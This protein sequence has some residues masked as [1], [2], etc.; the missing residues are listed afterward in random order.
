MVPG[1]N[2]AP[3]AAPVPTLEKPAP[4]LL[5]NWKLSVETG[6]NGL[7]GE[8]DRINTRLILN[9]RREVP[10][11]VTTA[12]IGWWYGETENVDTE[13]RAQVDLRTDLPA[14]PA[15]SWKYYVAGSAEY[16][17]FQPWDYRVSANAGF[18]YE[19][20]KDD[21]WT[22]L[23][24]AGLGS[25]YFEGLDRTGH[26]EFWP[27]VDLRF[28]IDDQSFVTATAEGVI[29]FQAFDDSRATIRA[30]YEI[31]LDKEKGTT[32][33]FGIEDRYQQTPV[34]SREDHNVEYFAALVFRF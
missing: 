28:K 11:S 33:K 25:T 29:D 7:S 14:S 19:V 34:E 27:G 18:G 32:L 17:E 2:P 16:N 22:V 3:S 20:F 5:D 12:V 24:R 21:S 4:S 15:S 9:A 26:V 1:P 31:L 23:T 30:S 6:L 13:N 8:T 10:D